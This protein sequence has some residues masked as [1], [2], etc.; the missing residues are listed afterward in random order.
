[1]GVNELGHGQCTRRC[2]QQN[3]KRNA[4]LR[5]EQDLVTEN[6]KTDAEN[7]IFIGHVKAQIKSVLYCITQTF[8]F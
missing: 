6:E 1:M 2:E 8:L 4:S 5:P 7:E 3:A